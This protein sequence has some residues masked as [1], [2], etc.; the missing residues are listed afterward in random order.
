M[1][2]RHERIHDMKEYNLEHYV[3]QMVNLRQA[4]LF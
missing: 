4:E 1:M 2:K 3:Q